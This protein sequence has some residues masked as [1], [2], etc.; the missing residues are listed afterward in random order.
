MSE[1]IEI[2]NEEYWSEFDF[3]LSFYGEF[4]VDPDEVLP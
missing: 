1:E 2:D 4:Y 3:A